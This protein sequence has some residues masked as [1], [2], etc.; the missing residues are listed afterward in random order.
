[1]NSVQREQIKWLIL[2]FCSPVY[3]YKL[4]I[5]VEILASFYDSG[6]NY[7]K[8][9]SLCVIK[10]Y[11]IFHQAKESQK[12]NTLPWNF[13]WALC[14]WYQLLPKKSYTTQRTHT[15]QTAQPLTILAP[16]FS[17]QTQRLSF[18]N[19]SNNNKIFNAFKSLKVSLTVK[20][21]P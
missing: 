4:F 2:G 21:N 13:R 20:I 14:H 11:V 15:N 7:A 5:L 1:M 3:Q 10:K 6:W 8:A 12:S 17:Q 19:N 16:F 9:A 18:W